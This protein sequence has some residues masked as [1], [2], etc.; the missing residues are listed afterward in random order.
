MG[1]LLKAL[2]WSSHGT[3]CVQLAN[4]A[5]QESDQY[6]HVMVRYGVTHVNANASRSCCERHPANCSSCCARACPP[7]SVTYRARCFQI[8]FRR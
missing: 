7:D 2:L 5:G 3:R 1:A 4:K 6:V 8:A